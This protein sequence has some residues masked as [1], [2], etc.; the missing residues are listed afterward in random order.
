M[1]IFADCNT[2]SKKGLDLELGFKP[3]NE[4]SKE[5]GNDI[6]SFDY[7]PKYEVN[8]KTYLEEARQ[9]L[10]RN[11]PD[12]VIIH[13]KKFR[14]WQE[15]G[16]NKP[17]NRFFLIQP[18]D[19]RIW[20]KLQ[21]LKSGMPEKDWKKVLCYYNPKSD[22]P[23]IPIFPINEKPDPDIHVLIEQFDIV[24]SHHWIFSGLTVSGI[25]GFGASGQKGGEGNRI[26][27]NS[28]HIVLDHCLIENVVKKHCLSID[29]SHY[30]SIQ[31]SIIR[32]AFPI[33]NHDN[34]GV[35]IKGGEQQ[36]RAQ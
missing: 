14:S 26:R 32:N 18:G 3:E 16:L 23:F 5:A 22:N 2:T 9:A 28:T 17:G 24:K 20:G 8:I 11:E 19:Y 27:S 6:T 34:I 15:V 7:I 31:N 36:C 10:A 21:V 35:L 25:Q 33:P 13:P 29:N 30:N 12:V 4:S 1:L